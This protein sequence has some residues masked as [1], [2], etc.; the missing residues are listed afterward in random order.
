[1]AKKT[2]IGGQ[3]ILEGIM[4]KGPSKLAIAVRKPDGEIVLDTEL[5]DSK[6]PRKKWMKLPVIRGAVGLVEAM[7]IGMD[8]IMYSASFIEVEDEKPSR[9]EQ[10][11]G[12]KGKKWGETLMILVSVLIALGL[13]MLLP[14]LLTSFLLPKET[15]TAFQKNLFEGV[16]RL[17]IFFIYMWA[18]SRMEEMKRLFSY[19]GAEHKTIACYEAEEELTVENVRKH[20]PYHPR[21]GTSFLF[22]VMIV[23]V[24]VLSFFG[25]PNPVMRMVIRLLMLPVIAGVTYEINRWIGGSDSPLVCRLAAPGLWVQKFATVREPDDG[26]IE[27]A[28]AAMKE[29]IPEEGEDDS[30]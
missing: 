8:A 30:W 13:F 25:W 10:K 16:V 5:L 15:T 1:M 26:M 4:M 9:M 17:L 2:T 23:S 14:N 19:H 27:V 21:C 28:I 7:S 22:M 20:S 24:I 18:V 11:W 3:A 6:F 12:E 29:V